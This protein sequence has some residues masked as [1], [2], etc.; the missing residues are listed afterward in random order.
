M[1]RKETFI[2]TLVIGCT[3][4]YFLGRHGRSAPAAPAP[5]PMNTPLAA[6]PIPQA[7]APA[8]SPQIAAV[9]APRATVKPA[10][11]PTPVPARAA[12]VAAL[13][14]PPAAGEVWK[15]NVHGHEPSKG[16]IDALVTV[17]EFTDFECPYCSRV[18]PTLAE[19]V[20]TWPTDVRVVFKN[21]PLSFHARARPAAR[22]ALAAHRQGQFWPMHDALFAN[23][24]ELSDADFERHAQS[25]GLDIERWKKDFASAAV[26]AE[27]DRDAAD[28]NLVKVAGTPAFFVNGVK[29]EGAKP[30]ADFKTIIDH[31]LVRARALVSQG[32]PRGAVYAEVQKKA[33]TFSEIGERRYGITTGNSPFLG[34]PAGDI[35]IHEFSD[36]ECPY[37]SQVGPTLKALLKDPVVGSRV[38]VVFKNYPLPSHSN[39]RPAAAAA[40]AAH[41]QGKFWEMHDVIFERQA[42]LSTDNLRIWA[43][44]AGL[45]MAGYDAFVS[46][47]KANDTMDRDMMEA[48]RSR[49]RATPTVFINGHKYEPA[50]GFSVAA[51]SA[52]I[53]KRFPAK[54]K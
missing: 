48:N 53:S 7:A 24:T 12:P 37:C 30:F 49:V 4:A 26:A 35:V 25:V 40:L 46:T 14:V 42:Q 6:A 50:S 1:I 2:I 23:Q 51:F 28:A 43:K 15:A 8:A 45:D 52:A 31:E 22:A 3:A 9:Q 17:V 44:E 10:P 33:K 36:F 11:A 18:G 29:L 34:N 13:K 16:P 41:A 27:V 20:K 38:K 39:A 19:I 5:T 21:Q 47:G 32:V 54:A